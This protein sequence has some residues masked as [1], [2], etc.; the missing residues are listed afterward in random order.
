MMQSTDGRL[1]SN[2][3]YNT[4]VKIAINFSMNVRPV[5]W[6]PYNSAQ[7]LSVAH[8]GRLHMWIAR[9]VIELSL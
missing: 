1:Y 4:P 8:D 6:F 5:G 9:E 3:K 7:S 2:L